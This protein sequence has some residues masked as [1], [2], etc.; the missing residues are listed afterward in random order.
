MLETDRRRLVHSL[1][2]AARPTDAVFINKNCDGS[3]E[4]F[5]SRYNTDYADT[6]LV[7]CL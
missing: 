4:E 3:I 6:I 1:I 5:Q 7:K 2:S